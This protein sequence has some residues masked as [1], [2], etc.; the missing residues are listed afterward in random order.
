M[1]LELELIWCDVS[2]T[3]LSCQERE[4]WKLLWCHSWLLARH[5]FFGRFFID[6]CEFLSNN[7]AVGAIA[8][9][10]LWFYS[11]DK[12]DVLVLV[13][14]GWDWYSGQV[15]LFRALLWPVEKGVFLHRVKVN[16]GKLIS[17]LLSIDRFELGRDW[18][19]DVLWWI[20]FN[21][22]LRHMLIGRLVMN[23]ILLHPLQLNGSSWIECRML[24]FWHIANR[25]I[26]HARQ[27]LLYR[28]TSIRMRRVKWDPWRDICGDLLAS[29]HIIGLLYLL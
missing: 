11:F 21:A 16:V 17:K 1:G 15:L 22:L 3:C 13:L 12:V 6:S 7:E 26:L 14:S 18:V 5:S 9:L 2:H 24:W 27:I 25:P 19:G 29:N 23:N 4:V 10:L 8:H 20:E 28:L